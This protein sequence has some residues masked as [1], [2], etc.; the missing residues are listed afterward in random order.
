VDPHETAVRAVLGQQV[1]V[2]AGR[3]LAGVLVA[4]HGRRLPAPSGTLTH[5]F[6][7]V[8]ALAGATLEELGMPGARREALRSVARALAEGAVC[9]GAGADRDE[10]E[11]ALLRLR[12]VGPW[13]AGYVR[14]RALGDPDVLLAGDAAVVAGLRCVGASA[15]DAGA[16]RPWR[17]Y[18]MHHL[19]IAA[20]GR[21]RTRPGATSDSRRRPT[22]SPAI[23]GGEVTGE[24][25]HDGEGRVR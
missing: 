8:E 15:R 18:A 21:R 13:T 3:R 1:S 9:L 5:L 11:R 7:T 23:V 12:G 16:W 22:P 10:A 19:W 20:A 6:P 17:T 24:D 4:A 2:A 14:M 25:V